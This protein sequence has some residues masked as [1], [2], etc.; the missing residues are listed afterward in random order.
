MSARLLLDASPRPHKASPIHMAQPTPTFARQQRTAPRQGRSPPPTFGED[1][2]RHTDT[3]PVVLRR[4]PGRPGQAITSG[5]SW[6]QLYE[7]IPPLSTLSLCHGLLQERQEVLRKICNLPP[8]DLRLRQLPTQEAMQQ[9]RQPTRRLHGCALAFSRGRR[10]HRARLDFAGAE[11][12]SGE[13][14][15]GVNQSIVRV[16]LPVAAFH[17]TL[18]AMSAF[19]YTKRGKAFGYVPLVL[20]CQ[21][22]LWL[23]P[24]VDPGSSRSLTL[25]DSVDSMTDLDF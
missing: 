5:H 15:R 24:G 11:S 1:L 21:A 4:I 9:K 7:D 10:T 13:G 3:Q 16:D 12:Q 2:Q 6:H 19:A 20:T 8:V 18:F 22:C 14:P 25:N 17:D 23:P